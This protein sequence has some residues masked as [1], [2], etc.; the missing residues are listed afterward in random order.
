MYLPSFSE[1][2]WPLGSS[3]QHMGCSPSSLAAQC[4]GWA[5]SHTSS[6]PQGATIL[7]N[8]ASVLNDP[9]FWESPQKSNLSHFLDKD[10]DFMVNEAFLP[11]SAGTGHSTGSWVVGRRCCGIGTAA[12]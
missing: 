7:P 10:G 8:L 4:Q 11:F 1:A 2:P 9:E 12:L 3:H 6:S 5:L